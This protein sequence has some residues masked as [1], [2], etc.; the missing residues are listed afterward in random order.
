MGSEEV[1]AETVID[2]A[3]LSRRQEGRP[4]WSDVTEDLN[5]NLVVLRAGDTVETHTNRE[6]DVLLVV[7]E[8]EGEVTVGPSKVRVRA[9]Q[10]LV[11]PKGVSRSIVGVTDHFGYITCHKR[12][13]GL[14]PENA[15]TR[16][17]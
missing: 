3:G 14:W 2:F 10:G 12:R 11:V 4:V 17:T 16:Q 15:R 1:R 13:A 9:G 8:G 6:V 5:L 7:V